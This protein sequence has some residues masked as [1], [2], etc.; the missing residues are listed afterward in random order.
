MKGAGPTYKI[1]NEDRA[2]LARVFFYMKSETRFKERCI[3]V[4]ERR[5]YVQK[6]RHTPSD[7]SR[8]FFTTLELLIQDG[9]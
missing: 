9:F 4:E 6:M 5:L 7:S 1:V 2:L 3:F 8:F